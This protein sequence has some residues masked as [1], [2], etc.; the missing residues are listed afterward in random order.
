MMLKRVAVCA[1]SLAA[2]A[3]ILSSTGVASADPQDPH[4]PDITHSFCPGGQ[5]GYG[6]LGVCDG[7]KYPDGSYWHQWMKTYLGGPKFYYDCVGGDEP[8][9]GPPPPGGCEG[10]IPA[11]PPPDAPPT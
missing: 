1:S 7:D 3:T 8:L 5:W 9:P 11:A 6:S 4:K 10:A 2:T